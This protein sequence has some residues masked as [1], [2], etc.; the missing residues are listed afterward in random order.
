M[1]HV[2]E[3][4]LK[5][6]DFFLDLLP[7]LLAFF[8]VE[9]HI[10]RFVLDAIG[11]DEGREGRGDTAE[12]RLVA[13]FL[14]LFELLPLLAHLGGCLHIAALASFGR[15]DVWMTED[16]FVAKFVA[17]LGDIELRL[18][19]SNF[20]VEADVEEHV[21][22][23]FHNLVRIAF[24][25]GIREFVRLFDGVGAQAFVGLLAVPGALLA[26]GVEDIKHTPERCEFFFFAV[27]EGSY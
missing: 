13:V 20:G 26:Q 17:D 6:S 7:H 14:L 3:F 2:F 19:F 15:I 21:A 1:V 4:G 23:F 12:D 5:L 25:Q 8:P 22:E 27:H 16:E 18:L 24:H 10:A 9:A 11:L